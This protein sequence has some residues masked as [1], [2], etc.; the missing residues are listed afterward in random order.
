MSILCYRS[1]KK[2]QKQLGINFLSSK[3]TIPF[4]FFFPFVYH[5]TYIMS[6]WSHSIIPSW[7]VTWLLLSDFS[8]FL[9][10]I[11]GDLIYL[12]VIEHLTL[13]S[14]HRNPLIHWFQA[15]FLIPSHLSGGLYTG[16]F[17]GFSPSA[18][19]LRGSTHC[20]PLGLVPCLFTL[21]MLPSLSPLHLQPTVLL[22][23]SDLSAF[24]LNFQL[25][26]FRDVFYF[27]S[28]NIF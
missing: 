12:K 11:S 15:L 22:Y 28:L 19:S 2:L 4:L 5:D 1:E 14:S 6:S 16:G 17:A 27:N 10:S 21:Q 26:S 13:T 18:P 7:E 24:R 20:S 23:T 8:C 3:A 9:G 25:V